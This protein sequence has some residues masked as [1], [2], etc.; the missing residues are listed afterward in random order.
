M[1]ATLVG[2]TDLDELEALIVHLSA[3]YEQG[4]P[5]VDFDEQAISDTEYDALVRR[6]RDSKPDA[7]VLSM[8]TPAGN[9]QL[10]H[11]GGYMTH[12]PPMTS[13]A[14]ADTEKREQIFRKWLADCCK[15]LGYDDTAQRFVI[16]YKL[17]GVALSIRYENGRLV[18]AGLRPRD[19]I[20]GTDVTANVAYV[21]GV[22]QKLPHPWS[23]TLRGEI[24]CTKEDFA[25]VQA[26]HLAAGEAPKANERNHAF[27]AIRQLKDPSKTAAGRLSFIGHGIVDFA[28]WEQHYSSVANRSDWAISRVLMDANFIPVKW[29]TD[30]QMEEMV[31][32]MPG[33]PYRVDGLVIYV[34]SL[35][36]QETLGHVGDDPTGDPRYCIAWKPDAE[37]AFAE[38]KE[39]TFEASRT[40]RVTLVANF[41]GVLLAGS[42]VRRATCNNIGWAERMGIGVGSTVK[43]IKGGEIIPKII[44]VTANP[45]KV[46]QY[47]QSC[48]ACNGPV[49]L[50]V[51]GD[52]KDLRCNNDMCA[53][54]HIKG[55]VHFLAKLECKGLGESSI[56]PLIRQ[57]KIKEWADL[58]RLTVADCVECGFSA[59]ESL[60]ALAT[61]HKI[62]PSKD[63]HRLTVT[64]M[65]ARTK[66]KVVPAWQ[67]FAALGIPQCGE[68]A[69]KLLVEH[70]R[71]F[72]RICTASLA[73]LLAVPG[74][75]EISAQNIH[76]FCKKYEYQI[77]RAA[78]HFE[79]ELPKTGTFT[80]LK[81]CLSGSFALGKEHWEALIM[82]KGGSVSG[83]VS[84][85][86]NYL[87]AGPGSGLKSAKATEY[88]IPIIDVNRLQEMLNEAT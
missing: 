24:I 82:G 72:R 87:V 27:G 83:S 60:L 78:N 62:K 55:I 46:V 68:T 51:N 50:V 18:Q 36:A 15:E 33:L 9:L 67:F 43:F 49:S 53:A 74:I 14:K 45:V 3:L 21:K 61:I 71:D 7:E 34:D 31:A 42:T 63:D 73:E 54:K 17:D 2:P 26:D 30:K 66:K 79:L 22:P 11:E 40:G 65:D 16:G 75:G 8:I 52:K 57:G 86:L 80:G 32:A 39:I 88:G 81:F 76:D 56:E 13:I 41:E 38:V 70:F 69:G 5:C 23:L 64:I 25:L 20:K 10:P 85:K 12:S 44:A 37:E 77:G 58:Y 35:R 29:C 48:P 47:P 4:L 6:L 1:T 19:G 84:K 59:R 28:D